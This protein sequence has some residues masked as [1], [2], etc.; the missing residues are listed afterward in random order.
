MTTGLLG[1]RF[2]YNGLSELSTFRN[3]FML[4][5]K[6]F[7]WNETEQIDIIQYCLKDKALKVYKEMPQEDKDS[8]MKIWK[9]MERK[10]SKPKQYY[11][12]LF[13]NRKINPGESV[14]AFCHAIQNLL[15]HGMPG[16]DVE[17]RDELLKSRLMVN[18]PENT[19]NFL[20]LMAEKKWS[21][22]V[23]IFDKQVDYKQME[24][25]QWEVSEINTINT[26][27]R[28]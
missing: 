2:I 21:E 13:Y 15:E 24:Q 28:Y 8:M 19:K 1:N 10:S 9:E 26:N 22:L 16:L 23:Q 3:A 17:A 4:E 14:A 5:A 7:G 20:E 18:V 11:L 12:N 6:I 27:Q 25:P